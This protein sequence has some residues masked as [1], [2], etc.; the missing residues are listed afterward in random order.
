[1]ISETYRE[2][3]YIADFTEYI[4]Q[5]GPADV[6]SKGVYVGT[7][8][9]VIIASFRLTDD[10]DIPFVVINNEKNPALFKKADGTKAPQ[11]ECIIFADRNDNKK[12]WMLFLELKYCK[13]KNLFHR[14]TEGVSQLS[15]SCNYIFKEIK[16]FQRK[17]FKIH[18]VISA[19]GI[20]PLEPFDGFYFDQEARLTIKEKTG[21]TLHVTNEAH[22]LTPAVV[23]FEA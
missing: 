4:N 15:D 19:P 8:E 21:A 10:N 6:P 12:A 1:M 18:L 23:A 16:L 11:C 22:I 9:N 14:L 3:I 13:E 5:G 20:T 17:Q 7:D 2:G